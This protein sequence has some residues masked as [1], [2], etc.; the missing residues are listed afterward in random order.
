MSPFHRKCCAP[1]ITAQCVGARLQGYFPWFDTQP[2]HVPTLCTCMVREHVWPLW[3]GIS[4]RLPRNERQCVMLIAVGLPLSITIRRALLMTVPSGASVAFRTA[5]NQNLE[6]RTHPIPPGQAAILPYQI[7]RST[8][9]CH[10]R[11]NAPH[12]PP[13]RSRPPGQVTPKRAR[14][15]IL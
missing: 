13:S 4:P 12:G 7:D 9:P 11:I 3:G 10:C 5:A 2:S 1:N 15:G 8:S 6:P 14:R